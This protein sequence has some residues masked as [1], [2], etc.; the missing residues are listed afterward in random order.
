MSFVGEVLDLERYCDGSEA[1]KKKS[2]TRKKR[3]RH[4]VIHYSSLFYYIADIASA[5]NETD[6]AL[7]DRAGELRRCTVDRPH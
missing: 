4:P 5:R 1:E 3:N 6:L 2:E 7:S